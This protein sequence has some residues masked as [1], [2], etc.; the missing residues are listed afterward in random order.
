MLSFEAK[1]YIG[2]IF[3]I[4]EIYIA[5]SIVQKNCLKYGDF[6]E[7]ENWIENDDLKRGNCCKIDGFNKELILLIIHGILHLFGYVHDEEHILDIDSENYDKE[8]KYMQKLLFG[9]VCRGL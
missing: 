8:M 6:W 3:H 1:E 7:K 9:I 4:G 5:P 2:D